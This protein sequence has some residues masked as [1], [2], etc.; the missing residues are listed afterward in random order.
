MIGCRRAVVHRS[1]DILEYEAEAVHFPDVIRPPAQAERLAVASCDQAA[2]PNFSV[3]KGSGEDEARL[4]G[5]D[6]PGVISVRS[7]GIHAESKRKDS[8]KKFQSFGDRQE[9]PLGGPWGEPYQTVI[10]ETSPRD[11]FLIRPSGV[12]PRRNEGV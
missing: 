3:W 11:R 2:A 8:S 9:M 6:R 5:R 12:A 10:C 1:E 4:V 7:A